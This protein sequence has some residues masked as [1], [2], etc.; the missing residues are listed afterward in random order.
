MM[1]DH[2]SV[3]L[4]QRVIW[5]LPPV[6]AIHVLEEA[7]GFTVWVNR[8]ASRNFSRRNFVQNNLSGLV[9]GCFLCFLVFMYPVR[10][11]VFLFFLG[12]VSQMFF[13]TVFHVWTALAFKAHAP[14]LYSS[15]LLYPALCAYLVILALREGLL[16]ALGLPLAFL[17]GGI[18]H[19][20]VIH[21]QV[22]L[23]RASCRRVLPHF[24]LSE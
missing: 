20:Y 6:F 5:L 19:A 15:I 24:S 2:G 3:Y 12:A 22:F 10:A 4:F 14:G 23:A 11:V 1:P 17:A 13:N 18:L 9:A 16:G 21:R 7:T 8:Y